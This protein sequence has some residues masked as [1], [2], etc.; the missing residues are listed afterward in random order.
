MGSFLVGPIGSAL[1]VLVSV[2]LGSLVT[3]LAN[4]NT[5]D[6]LTFAEVQTWLGV[7]VATA[8]P[9]IIAALNPADTRFGRTA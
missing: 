1:R 8:L 5:F 9:I 3:Y 4:G 7:A 2:L 6:G